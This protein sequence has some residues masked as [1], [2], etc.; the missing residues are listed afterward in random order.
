MTKP[1]QPFTDHFDLRKTLEEYL[2]KVINFNR[3]TSYPDTAVLSERFLVNLD[4][5]SI[6]RTERY[7]GLNIE[8]LIT[9]RL[10][11]GIKLYNSKIDPV[12]YPGTAVIEADDEKVREFLKYIGSHI[13]KNPGYRRYWEM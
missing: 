8:P 2:D 9:A 6:R 5:A 1:V 10:G 3:G 13:E 4:L 7:Q 11:W 12:I